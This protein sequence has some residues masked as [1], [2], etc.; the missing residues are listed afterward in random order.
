LLWGCGALLA[1]HWVT[2][3]Q[4]I[5]VSTVAVGLLAYS[6][7]P[8]FAALLEPPWLGER[9]S[10]RALGCALACLAGV[11]LIVPNWALG[12][13]PLRGVA[14]GL[15]AGLSFAVLSVLNRQLVRRHSAL[16]VAFHQDLA[17]LVLLAPLLP[18]VWQP[19]SVA[20]VALLGVLGLACTAL[21]H[22][23]FI[24]ALTAIPARTAAIAS[25]LEPVYGIALAW[26]LLGQPLTV[27]TLGGGAVI[28]AAVL[29]ATLPLSRPHPEPA[30]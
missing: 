6:T 3:F 13:A 1:L 18:A 5:Q 16:Q 17:A 20:D 29:F 26:F 10:R 27:R 4:A 22:T 25:A 11:A 2:F 7:A 21:A 15:A 19:L 12:A 30:R 23:L 9:F 14:W 8:A 28:V 24:W